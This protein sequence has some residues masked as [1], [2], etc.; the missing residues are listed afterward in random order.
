[1]LRKALLA[2]YFVGYAVHFIP[3]VV[4]ACG[5]GWWDGWHY[6]AGQ[7]VVSALW[8]L[9]WAYVLFKPVTG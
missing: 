3:A 4:V 2:I 1:M 9:A 8:P 7:L 5:M 6:L